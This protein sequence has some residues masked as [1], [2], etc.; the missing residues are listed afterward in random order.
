MG[1][2][3]QNGTFNQFFDNNYL[4]YITELRCLKEIAFYTMTG[5][6]ISVVTFAMC[7]FLKCKCRSIEKKSE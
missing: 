6:V 5:I 3:A 7:L 4:L 2:G 1:D